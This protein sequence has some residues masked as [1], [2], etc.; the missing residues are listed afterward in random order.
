RLLMAFAEARR[1]RCAAAMVFIS[2]LTG[3]HTAWAVTCSSLPSP[4]YG[5]GGSAQKPL[6]AKVGAGLT[7]ANPAETFIYQ[8][9]G[10]CLGPNSIISG[11]KLTG[12]A[13]YWDAAGTEQQCDLPLVGQTADVGASGVFA[14]EC[15]G[16]VS[17]PSD[18]GDFVGPVQAFG[19]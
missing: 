7:N 11:T 9:P 4:I 6:F 10:A 16:I 18:V 2:A 1:R 15:P 3:A 13:S 8:A 17:L 19:F 12:T 14:T 5:I